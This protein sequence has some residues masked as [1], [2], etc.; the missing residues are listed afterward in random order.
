M[1]ATSALTTQ[2][3]TVTTTPKHAKANPFKLAAEAFTLPVAALVVA[4]SA[5]LMTTPITNGAD[6]S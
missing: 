5:F 4:A 2:E 6:A 1:T 3:P